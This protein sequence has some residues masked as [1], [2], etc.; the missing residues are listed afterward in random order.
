M[1]LQQ[2]KGL[3]RV[4][5]EKLCRAGIE[6][7]DQLREIGAKEALLRVRRHADPGACLHMLYALEAALR[8]VPKKELPPA[9]KAD[10]KAFFDGL[11][12]EGQEAAAPAAEGEET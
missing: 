6:T 7:P 10:L 1:E 12:E 9:V 3:G 8:G 11:A 2:M 5:A 4:A